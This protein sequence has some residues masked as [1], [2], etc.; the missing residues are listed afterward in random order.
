MSNKVKPFTEM[1]AV[2]ALRRLASKW[3]QGLTLFARNGSL[4]V[5]RDYGRNGRDE[6][7]KI[8]DVDILSNSGDTAF[9]EGEPNT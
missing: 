5:V 1:E 7:V 8:A 9:E 3:P 6:G 4:E 2:A